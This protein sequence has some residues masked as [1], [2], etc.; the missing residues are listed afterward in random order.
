M[1]LLMLNYEYPPI[2]G[3]GGVIHKLLAEELA[4]EHRVT[5]ITS[6]LRG[7]AAREIINE[8]EVVRVPV[9]FRKGL[10]AASLVSMLSFPPSSLWAG[11]QLLRKRR[12]DLIHSMFAVPSGVPG[13]LLARF[14]GL[15]HVVS[16]LGGDIYDPSRRLSPHR[17]PILHFTVKKVLQGAS[18]ITGMS[19][20][21]ISKT[22]KFFSFD[23]ELVLIPHAIRQP[24][25]EKKSRQSFGYSRDEFLLVT[26][27]R[28]IR[29]KQVDALLQIF[30]KLLTRN[31]PRARLL[32]IG[33]GPK[34]AELE[35]LASTL[36]ID[37]KVDFLGNVGDEEKFQLLDLGD[38]FVSTAEHEGFGLV[39]LE[40]MAV[41]LP[42]VCYDNGGQ[43]DF[44]SDSCTGHVVKL[45][46]GTAFER[47]LRQLAQNPELL[48]EIGRF[49]RDV[50]KHYYI[51][52]CASK[53]VDL[54]EKVLARTTDTVTVKLG[55]K[56][57][58]QGSK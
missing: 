23:S 55:K 48:S 58:L 44:L 3:G 14:F 40:A 54:Y 56:A 34:R 30:H 21:I 8:V 17:M 6:R 36:G 16:V 52:N 25:F 20:D 50:I 1:N 35:D 19:N 7:Q 29:R 15:P 32:V 22:R 9:L 11:T 26:I 47:R 49:N 27:G 18:R 13:T 41:G 51:E 42:I 4:K 45:N 39:F 28:L 10:N 37:S 53:Y 2:G 38:V 31:S 12:F 24:V 43:T 33:D 46:D 5:V 57:S